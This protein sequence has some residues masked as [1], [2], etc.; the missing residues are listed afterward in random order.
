MDVVLVKPIKSTTLIKLQVCYGKE[1]LGAVRG[2]QKNALS[3]VPS[4]Q[5]LDLSFR[6]GCDSVSF[7]PPLTAFRIHQSYNPVAILFP[8]PTSVSQKL[9]YR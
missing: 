8:R 3:D 4:L 6:V 1:D 7:T 2:L 5:I 9:I